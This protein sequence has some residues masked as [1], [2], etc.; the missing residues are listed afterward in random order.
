MRTLLSCESKPSVRR[1]VHMAVR[2]PMY[3]DIVFEEYGYKVRASL[4]FGDS[5][6]IGW[7]QIPMILQLAQFLMH[8]IVAVLRCEKLV[9]CARILFSLNHRLEFLIDSTCTC[10]R[11]ASCRQENEMILWRRSWIVS[12]FVLCSGQFSISTPIIHHAEVIICMPRGL[13]P[14]SRKRDHHW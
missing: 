4:T 3:A 10:P 9:Q 12:Y 8:R 14:D 1:V 13:Y 6:S 2:L 11:T 7:F 5:Q